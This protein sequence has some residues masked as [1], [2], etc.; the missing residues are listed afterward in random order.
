MLNKCLW[1]WGGGQDG[2]RRK[3]KIEEGKEEKREGC[4]IRQDTPN[5]AHDRRQ[6]I[7][8]SYSVN[9]TQKQ[10][11]NLPL[12]ALQTSALYEFTLLQNVCLKVITLFKMMNFSSPVFGR[13]GRED[14]IV[15][16]K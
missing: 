4:T 2:E 9:L 5:N 15:R 7:L 3:G 14:R 11:I 16:R 10:F 13:W 8:F 1:K 6:P 12:G